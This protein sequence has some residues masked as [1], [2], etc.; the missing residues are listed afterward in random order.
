MHQPVTLELFS[1]SFC[2]AC[3]RTRQVLDQVAGL[4]P[5][6]VVTEHNVAFEPARADAAGITEVPT[7]IV[8]NATGAEVSRAAGVP[9]P[10]QVVAAL[11]EAIT[12]PTAPPDGR[13]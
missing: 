13:S 4:V 9:S 5:G 3:S 10:D 8:R 12:P 6:V 11:A 2:G 1:Q 7:V